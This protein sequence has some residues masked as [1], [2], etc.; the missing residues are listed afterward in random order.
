[1]SNIPNF[2]V[3]AAVVSSHTESERNVRAGGGDV[4]PAQFE[5]V[6]T[7]EGRFARL[8]V[9]NFETFILR[10]SNKTTRALRTESE[11]CARLGVSV[12]LPQRLF[13]IAG[14]HVVDVTSF[15]TGQETVWIE[16]VP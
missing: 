4:K 7:N 5:I 8:N 13:I 10:G 3:V 15:C 9:P 16:M 6:F 14:V 12:Q 1:M 2:K 11:P